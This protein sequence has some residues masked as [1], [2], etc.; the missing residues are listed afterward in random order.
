[1]AGAGHRRGLRQARKVTVPNSQEKAAQASAEAQRTNALCFRA[2]ASA[3]PPCCLQVFLPEAHAACPSYKKRRRRKENGHTFP[4]LGF[5]SYLYR[6]LN[7]RKHEKYLPLLPSFIACMHPQLC[8][9]QEIRFH[10]R[11]LLLYI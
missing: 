5:Y 7:V 8:T 10:P 4:H 2:F 1:M 11:R 3:S 9:V 6:Q